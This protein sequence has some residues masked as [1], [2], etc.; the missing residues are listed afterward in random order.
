MDCS[1]TSGNPYSPSCIASTS[2]S[3]TSSTSCTTK[4]RI[5]N[6]VISGS[7]SSTSCA[8]ASLYEVSAPPGCNSP[9]GMRWTQGESD[10]HDL[11]QPSPCRQRITANGRVY[12]P[13]SYG[14]DDRYRGSCCGWMATALGSL[15]RGSRMPFT[16]RESQRRIS[17]NASARQAVID[18]LGGPDA[19]RRIPNVF[20]HYPNSEDPEDGELESIPCYIGK[21]D[22][23]LFTT[24]KS[25]IV[26]GVDDTGRA[27]VAVSVRNRRTGELHTGVLAQRYRET[28]LAGRYGVSE[29]AIWCAEG[30]LQSGSLTAVP[31][32]EPKFLAKL[33]ALVK[34]EDP[35][36]RLDFARE[37]F[38]PLRR[39]KTVN[40]LGLQVRSDR[41]D[42]FLTRGLVLRN[43]MNG[44]A[45]AFI[46]PEAAKQI[47][48]VV[49]HYPADPCEPGLE[50]IDECP[51]EVPLSIFTAANSSVVQ[52]CDT[53]GRFILTVCVENRSTGE[54]KTG[55]LTQPYDDK[56]SKA[57]V[58]LARAG[59]KVLPCGQWA[60]SG[61]LRRLSPFGNVV[62][63]EPDTL[64]GFCCELSALM[65]GMDPVWRL[66][67]PSCSSSSGTVATGYHVEVIRGALAVPSFGS[68]PD[69]SPSSA[70]YSSS[71][72]DSPSSSEGYS[73]P[74]PDG[75]VAHGQG[76]GATSSSLNR[77]HPTGSGDV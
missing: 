55:L 68:D 21:I 63:I 33:R 76:M 45:S 4:T 31:S 41:Q 64:T 26:Q 46:G 50:K 60:V 70:G 77:R 35:E 27:F 16:P 24:Q 30:V 1:S 40:T 66:T 3:C 15:W 53:L 6:A 73:S 29:G 25:S 59:S 17:V 56:T 51:E 20:L 23:L 58:D 22:R 47:P 44:F 72:P 2:T 48:V 43:V 28:T 71:D 57:I 67:L 54:I 38:G 19:V 7:F 74:D 32:E 49:L 36:W 61:V 8:T 42:L 62:L 65:R 69:G 14:G 18:A 11:T 34:D 12:S 9:S 10:G 75:S 13:F 39:V 37:P 52:G 5:P